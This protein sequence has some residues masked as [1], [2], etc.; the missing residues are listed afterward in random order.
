MLRTL[1]LLLFVSAAEQ[2]A[3]ESVILAGRG[4]LTLEPNGGIGA[5]LVRKKTAP[6]STPCL[7]SGLGPALAE[8]AHPGPSNR[9][10]ARVRLARK[11]PRRGANF[12]LVSIQNQLGVRVQR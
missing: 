10:E 7:K 1:F 9:R 5:V 2:L 11:P 6:P 4:R 12:G 3:Y 8:V